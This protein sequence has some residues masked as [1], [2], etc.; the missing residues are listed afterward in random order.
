MKKEK[1]ETKQNKTQKGTWRRAGGGE[2]V[3][4]AEPVW[5]VLAESSNTPIS[6]GDFLGLLPA[7][8]ANQARMLPHTAPHPH[9]R[10][11]VTPGLGVGFPGKNP[12]HGRWIWLSIMEPH[13][14]SIVHS[15][16]AQSKARPHFPVTCWA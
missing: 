16:T 13:S 1:K 5:A 10:S 8:K 15:H 14:L 6:F 12:T 9:A 4:A 7:P 11:T 3:S 2:P